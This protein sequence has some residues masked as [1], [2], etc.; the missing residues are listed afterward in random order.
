[1]AFLVTRR[2]EDPDLDTRQYELQA[3]LNLDPVREKLRS[4]ISKHSAVASCT[5]TTEGKSE[6]VTVRK[7]T[8]IDWDSTDVNRY[9]L[10]H[11]N[12]AAQKAS[13]R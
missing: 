10:G 4:S 3:G 11:I 7:L 5:I 2:G 12:A 9:V 6:V 8:G 13:G 1:M